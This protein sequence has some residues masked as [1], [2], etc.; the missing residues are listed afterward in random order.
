MRLLGVMAGLWLG[1][2]A[3]APVQAATAA[4]AILVQASA[5]LA[6]GQYPEAKMLA[7]TGLSEPA[8]EALIRS[9]L[10]V[11]R[12]LAQQALGD[13]DEA[14]LDLTTGLQGAPLQGEERARALFA[15]GL[16]LD[17]QGRLEAAIGDYSAALKFSPHA[18]YALNN[19]ANVYRRQGRFAEAKRDYTAALA[20]NTPNPQYPYYGLGQIG[21]AEG[22]AQAARGFYSRALKADPGFALARERLQSIGAPLEEAAEMPTD[23][24]V[25]VLRPPPREDAPFVLR[26]PS[27]AST[28]RAQSVQPSGGLLGAVPPTPVADVPRPRR[29]LAPAPPPG[30]GAP[31]RPAITEGVPAATGLVQLGAWRSEAE[32]RAGWAVAKAGAEGLLDGLPPVIV[33]VVLPERGT[34][35]RLRVKARGPATSFCASMARRGLAC[36]PVRD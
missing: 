26:P 14:L 10:L 5:A 6:S 8:L 23:A 27:A 12:G 9:R 31:L 18:A 16:S 25:I 20:A 36:L 24:G 17:G 28:A 19:R 32:A 34:F 21:E 2:L 11:I 13:A 22:D 1:G 30:R 3:L 7:S 35:Y 33:T 4:D 15:R 29:T